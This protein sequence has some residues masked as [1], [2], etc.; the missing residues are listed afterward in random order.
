MKFLV[1]SCISRFVVT[2]LRSLGHEVFWVPEEGSDP[3]DEAILHKAVAEGYVLVTADKDF[4]DLV[5]IYDKPHP[6][7][8]RLVELPPHVPGMILADVISRHE[9]DIAAQSL[10]T[11]GKRKIRVRPT[12]RGSLLT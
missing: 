8:I 2:T 5:F 6:C 1:D 3:G 11:V 9:E 4:G 10:I 12:G 7:I